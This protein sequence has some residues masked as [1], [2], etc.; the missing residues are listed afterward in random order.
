MIP[1]GKLQAIRFRLDCLKEQYQKVHRWINR[2]KFDKFQNKKVWVTSSKT[3]NYWN[4][5]KFFHLETM[6]ILEDVL[7]LLEEEL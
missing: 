1:K 5:V 7:K 4:E 3:R 2:R 6:G